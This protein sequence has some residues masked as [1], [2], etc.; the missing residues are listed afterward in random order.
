[1]FQGGY[2]QA[3]SAFYM[4]SGC[5][6]VEVVNFAINDCFVEHGNVDALRERFGINADS[7]IEVVEEFVRTT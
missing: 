2:G 4:N 6:D 3:V 7:V 5:K 1:M